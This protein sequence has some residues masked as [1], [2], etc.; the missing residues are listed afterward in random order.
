M[1]FIFGKKVITVKPKSLFNNRIINTDMLLL[2]N[3]GR[4]GNMDFKHDVKTFEVNAV[5]DE[6]VLVSYTGSV[7]LLPK[8]DFNSL[9]S[10][11]GKLNGA[12][13]LKDSL[14]HLYLNEASKVREKDSEIAE[15][16]SANETAVSDY[17]NSI[18]GTK[19]NRGSGNRASAEILARAIRGDSLSDILKG[20]YTYNNRGN[21]KV[22]ERRKIFFALSVKKPEDYERILNLYNSYP[23]VFDCTLEELSAWYYKRLKKGVGSDEGI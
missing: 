1:H 7:I 22:Y 2:C 15:L 14:L 16:K 23:S 13:K 3:E 11:R 19:S 18:R 8:I 17:F 21:K 6:E 5:D 12:E 9:V 4:K 20:R 10:D